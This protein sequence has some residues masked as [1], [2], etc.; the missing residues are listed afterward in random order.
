MYV[1]GDKVPVRVFK[2]DAWYAFILP[3]GQPK[4][5]T[6]EVPDG[7]Q[8]EAKDADGSWLTNGFYNKGGKWCMEG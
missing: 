2:N 6:M 5:V 8:P 3:A 4:K 7:L 1:E